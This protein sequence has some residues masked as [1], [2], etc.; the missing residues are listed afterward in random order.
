MNKNEPVKISSSDLENKNNKNSRSNNIKLAIIIAVCFVV[1][2]GIYYMRR[3]V[4]AATVNGTSI[5]RLEVIKEL[6]KRSGKAVLDSLITQKLIDNEAK[7]KN[8]IVTQ[9]EI[10]QEVERGETEAI[11]RGT[12]LKQALIKQQILEDDFQNGIRIQLEIEKLLGDK[13]ELTDLEVQNYITTNKISVPKGQEII[14]KDQIKKQ[15]KPQK[16][17]QIG[18]LFIS[19]LKSKAKIDYYV[20][21]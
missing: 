13:A 4:I 7:N 10:N 1:L 12:T 5:S 19:D 17:S 15:L 8:I 16:L 9:D 21:Y 11:Q 20:N 6:E 3:F 2:G 18:K 14:I